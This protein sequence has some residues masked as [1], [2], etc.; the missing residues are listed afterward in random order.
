VVRIGGGPARLASSAAL[1]AALV[2]G[3]VAAAA[4][5]AVPVTL[6]LA[7]GTA[8]DVGQSA[9]LTARAR[10]PVGARL[11]IQRFAPGRGAAKVAECP[12]SP[13]TGAF[14]DLKQEVVAFQAFAIKR[15]G[16]KT[17]ILGRSKRLT[18]SWTVPPRKP[19]T[20][21][22]TPPAAI[23][24]HYEGKTAQNEVFRFDVAPSGLALT[25]L[26]TGQINE[27]CD[28]RLYLSGGNIR[29]TGSFAIAVDGTFSIKLAYGGTVNGN[30]SSNTLSV[31]GKITGG[32]ASGT[33]K[34]D[35]S[36]TADDGNGYACTS[37]EQTWSAARTG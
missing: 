18:V 25:N 33:Y 31:S 11:L 34:V 16:K 12:R 3:T 19:P 35:T 1:V 21:P 24:G 14:R 36:F 15:D 2:G 13:C 6:T 5:S 32:A 29:T 10:L 9:R 4:G 26:Q 20:T 22:A 27:T 17:T 23:P 28:P 8:R 30:P 7:G 37:G